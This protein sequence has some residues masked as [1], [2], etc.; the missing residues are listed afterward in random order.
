MG[1]GVYGVKR[2]A[3]VD[4]SDIEVIVLYSK[5]RNS[6]ETQTVTKLKGTDVIKQVFDPTNAVEVLGGMYNLE[7]PKTVFNARG[8]YTVYIRPAQ[9]RIQIEDCAELATFPD[10]KGLVFNT[11]NVPTEFQSKFT[12]NGLDGYRVE[13]LNENGSKQSNI[14]RIITSSF[15]VEPVQVDTPNSSVKTIKY[16]YNNVGSLLFCT[17]TPNAAPS[18][19]PTATPFIGYKGQNV[20]ITNTSFTPQILEVELVNYDIESLAIALY[21]NQTKSM[22]DGIYTL[23]DFDNNIYAQYDL[24]EIKDST[25]NKLYEVRTKRDNIDTT[26]D[27]N[28][29]VG[30]G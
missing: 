10:I 1:I 14:Y 12:N 17:V 18:F 26:K 6:T 20:I 8:Y 3:D 13:Y 25:D 2:P 9:I 11:T 5:T 4:P 30:N 29:I 27:L 15:I 22:E 21:S 28:N 24:Y 19:K 16:T 7:L 23:Y